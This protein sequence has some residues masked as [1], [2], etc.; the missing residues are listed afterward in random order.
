[1]LDL[2]MLPFR[3]CWEIL[4]VAFRMVGGIFSLLFSIAGGLMSLV[5]H[6]VL[7]AAGVG[8]IGM[9]IAN[10]RQARRSSAPKDEDFISY[11]DQHAV[12]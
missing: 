6:A 11:Y 3:L 1:M 12:K 7:I 10:R 4:C 9:L 2:L 8:V 5:V